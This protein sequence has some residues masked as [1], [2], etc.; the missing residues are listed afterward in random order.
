MG[1]LKRRIATLFLKVFDGYIIMTK[2]LMD[3]YSLHK[4]NKAKLFLLP[5]TISS[6]RFD[7]IVKKEHNRKYIAVVFGTH[8][9]DG[10]FESIQAYEQYLKL[11]KKTPLSLY[12]IGNYQKIPNKQTIDNF[13]KDKDLASMICFTG[14]VPIGD[15]PQYLS[16]AR[17]LL[18]TANEYSSGGFPTKIGE[19]MLSGVP[20]VATK[21]GELPLYLKDKYDV[22]F[23]EPRDYQNIALTIYNINQNYT[24]ALRVADNAKKTALNYFNATTYVEDLKTFIE[25]L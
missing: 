21:V 1:C 20:I 6:N 18:T 11:E 4:S 16:D 8:N 10:L 22:Y 19:Y 7:N 24:A 15:V 25:S 17:V 12:L 2:E 3:F 9:R 23:V 14:V 5:M 13:I